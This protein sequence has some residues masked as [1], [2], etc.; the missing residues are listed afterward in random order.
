MAV[1]RGHHSFDSH[2]TQIPNAWLRDSRLS[3]KAIGLLAQLM[4]HNPGW[5]MSIRSL[6]HANG[7]GTD[8]IKSAIEELEKYGYLTRSDQKHDDT[9][10]WSDFDYTTNDPFEEVGVTRNPVTVKSRHGETGHKEE[11]NSLEEQVLENNKRTNGDF[12]SL[13]DP[14]WVYYPRKENKQSARRA[15]KS[16]L[17]VVDAETIIEGA[18]RFGSD[19]NLPPTQYIPHAATWLNQ[20][21]WE[22]GP[23]PER[24]KTPDEIKNEQAQ[25]SREALDKDRKATE[26]WLA[27]Q[28]RHAEQV[29][30][31]PPKRCEHDR[32]EVLC[33]RCKPIG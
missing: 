26:E 10:K 16:A 33:P 31:N 4:S 12:D 11:H 18:K 2:F 1:I 22:N 20:S 7:C 32:I 29:R 15:F 5:N 17:K 8:T 9:G 21:R 25:R 28:A 30:L 27:E 3:L 23:L 6:A 13:F 24:I 14:F 19:P